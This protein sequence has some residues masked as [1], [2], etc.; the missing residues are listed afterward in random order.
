MAKDYAKYASIKRAPENKKGG[1]LF[2]AGILFLVIAV[3][4]VFGFY[5]YRLH[6]EGSP[7]SAATVLAKL[8]NVVSHKHKNEI[9]VA[10][11]ST[12]VVK[13]EQEVHFDF[14][15]ELPNMQV[16]VAPEDDAAKHS[17]VPVKSAPTSTTQEAKSGYIV[18]IRMLTSENEASE[19]RI[20]LLL[21]GTDAT[22]IKGDK[23]YSLQQG[24]YTTLS[25]AKKAQKQLQTKGID[26]S[27]EKQ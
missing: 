11:A 1:H 7:I 8:K 19:M 6:M 26:C 23:G 9:T 24:P 2:L 25:Q 3:M 13:A 17:V 27:V 16:K 10:T 4:S 20:S 5:A 12:Q 18:R 21:N 22:I 14:Y 15:D